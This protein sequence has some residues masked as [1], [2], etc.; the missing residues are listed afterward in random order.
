M[1]PFK[2][3]Q[4]SFQTNLT[5][6]QL[7][8]LLSTKVRKRKLISISTDGELYGTVNNKGATIELGQSFQRN[9]FRPVV[10]FKWSSKNSKTEI[11]G[12]YRVSLSVIFTT[13]FIPLL[14]L[15]LT[16][17]INNILPFLFLVIMWILL[18]L[19][20]GR[21]LFNKDFKWTQEEFFKLIRK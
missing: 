2:T 8:D 7:Q 11:S 15:Y 18:Y 17:K 6:E 20:F 13:L 19:T 21:W 3:K 14:G 5:I 4:F 10:A 12:Y 9:S 1:F 16:I